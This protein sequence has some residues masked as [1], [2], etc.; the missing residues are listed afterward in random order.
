MNRRSILLWV[1][2]VAMCTATQAQ[3]QSSLR[4]LDE[5]G[6]LTAEC[7]LKHT[8]V[9]AEVSGFISRVTVTQNFENPFSDKIEAVYTF[10]LPQMAAVDDLT[11]Q[12]G[13]RTIKGK[14][15]RRAEAAE[16]YAAAKQMGKVAS[17]LDQQRANVFTQQVAN[18]LPGQQIRVTISYVETLKYEDGAY[19]WTFPMVVAPRYTPEKSED[20]SSRVS[21]PVG[22]R[23]GHDVSLE[24]NLDAGMPIVNVNSTSHEIEVV[25]LDHKRA[26][27]RLRDHATI[28]N[29]DFLLTYGVAGDTI[30]D[31]VL[32]HHSDRGGFFTLILQPPQ[33][34]QA[35]DVMPKEMV[36]VL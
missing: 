10:P 33:R 19:E 14:I 15:M 20:N 23:S 16:A 22:M 13:D 34:V 2:L 36:F 30:K 3:S 5:N 7:P 32:A 28:P 1:A 4:V 35:E 9:K 24:I 8:A 25:P 27:V 31:A 29:K 21:P 6:K 17:L 12:I 26:V 11:M 18:I